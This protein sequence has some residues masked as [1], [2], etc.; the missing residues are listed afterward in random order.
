M[1]DHSE[2][3]S[4]KAGKDVDIVDF[5]KL[6]RPCGNCPFLKEGAIKLRS[7]RVEGILTDLMEDDHK[8]FPCHKTLSGA[9]DEEGDYHSSGEEMMCAGAAA[10]LLKRG[11]PTV[12][13]RL[14][15][16]FGFVKPEHWEAHY[17]KTID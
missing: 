9:E 4:T 17:D 3:T 8:Q 5:Y 13:M 11:M 7:G 1:C 16:T 15:L 2:E 14:A 6:K 10:V 12:G